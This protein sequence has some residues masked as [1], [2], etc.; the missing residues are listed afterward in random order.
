MVGFWMGVNAGDET[1][2]KAKGEEI[3]KMRGMGSGKMEGKTGGGAGSRVEGGKGSE[4]GGRVPWDC[5]IDWDMAAA[6]VRMWVAWH[7][8]VGL[9]GGGGVSLAAGGWSNFGGGKVVPSSPKERL[10]VMLEYEDKQVVL[11]EVCAE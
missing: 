9:V 2:G 1:G 4:A 5:E 6:L 7:A 11:S 8:L 10:V 3:G